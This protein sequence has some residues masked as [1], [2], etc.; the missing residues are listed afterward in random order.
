MAERTTGAWPRIL[1]TTLAVLLIT[2]GQAGLLAADPAAAAGPTPTSDRASTTGEVLAWGDNDYGQTSVP[3]EARSGVTAIAAK[4]SHS[5]ALKDGKVL[6]WGLRQWA[7]AVCR[8]RP[9]PG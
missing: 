3:V 8:W 4:G 6:A 1:A 5:L 7:D 2:I 9:S